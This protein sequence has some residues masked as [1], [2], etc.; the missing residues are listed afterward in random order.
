MILYNKKN[1][2]YNVN[3]GGGFEKMNIISTNLKDC[4]I[5]EPDRF[6]DKRGY[7]SPF[8]IEEKNVEK[9]FAFH[10]MVQ[11]ARSMSNK[12]VLRG[13][14]FQDDPY[15]QAKLVECL[16]G[17]V[18]DVVVDLRKDSPTYKQWTSVLLNPENG[19]Q[20]L[21][22]RGFAH[23]FLS[24][25][26]KTLF[27][28]L[29]DSDYR[30]DKELGI[31]P[32][33]P[34]INI[35]WQLS[36]YGI[37]DPIIKEVDQNRPNLKEVEDQINF[38][39]HKRYLVTGATGR[40]GYD[41]VRELNKLGIYD[42]LALGSKDLDITNE[43]LVHKIITE[44]APEY[45]I[46]CAAWTKVDEAEEKKEACYD[47]NVNGTKYITDAAR[48]VGAKLTF[49][50]TD[51]VFDGTK[52]TPYEVTDSVCPVNY[53]G[54]TKALAEDI[55][56]SYNKHF[57]V[58]TSWVFGIHGKNFVK[59][60]LNLSKTNDSIR[61][62]GDQFGTPTYTKDLAETLVKMQETKKYGTYHATNDGMTNWADF[63][64]Y[65]LAA[66]GIDEKKI[67]PIPTEEYPTKAARPHYSVLS[68]SS[69][70]ENGF[71]LLRSWNDAID[72]CSNELNNRYED[73]LKRIKK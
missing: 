26:D 61:V 27:Q 63:A 32:F 22:P 10:K 62:V 66:N 44:Y 9:K 16:S 68:K 14:H 30:P 65:S 11:G 6:G 35:D 20:L 45:I 60:M 73:D 1:V 4:Y 7:Y 18:L 29:V 42:I 25:K 15:S 71:D 55:V 3:I 59:T 72:D 41:V 43:R 21:V 57:I 36:E 34:D 48:E 49:I 17:E 52:N 37:T 39:M 12:G 33:D 53:Y 56:R 50:S 70:T 64:K 40:L 31:N 23:G 13:L 54:Y 2:I 67:I 28:Y 51:Y 38:Y 69:L 19:R 58:R 8:Y 46:H 5:I 24:L 47:V